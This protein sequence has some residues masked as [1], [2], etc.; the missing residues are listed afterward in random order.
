MN[1]IFGDAVNLLPDDYVVLELDTV[2]VSPMNQK[3]KT[4]CVLEMLNTS[5]F[6]NFENNKQLH[7]EL[8]EQYRCRNWSRALDIIG[9]L[10]GQWGKEIDSFYDVLRSRISNLQKNPPDDTWDGC[11]VKHAVESQNQIYSEQ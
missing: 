2:L 9:I 1:I 3:V 7:T 8:L 10:T 11:I 6:I 5:D 4:W